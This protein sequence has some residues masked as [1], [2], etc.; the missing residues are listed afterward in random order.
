MGEP[1]SETLLKVEIASVF[2]GWLAWGIVV[3]VLLAGGGY[4]FFG[5]GKRQAPEQ[6]QV[7]KEEQSV[8]VRQNRYLKK[9]IKA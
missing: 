6:V 2:S 7:V 1:D 4:Y 8:A 3:A 9:S 5:R